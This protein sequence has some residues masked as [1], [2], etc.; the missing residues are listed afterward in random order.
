MKITAIRKS[1][2]EPLRNLYFKVRRGT[3][4]WLD[5]SEF[6]LKDFDR[7]TKGELI[8]VAHLNDIPV[9]FISIWMRDHFIHHLY[10]DQQ[11]QGKN[12]GTQLLKAAIAKTQLPI[13]LKC[14]ENNLKAVDFYLKK[15]FIAIERGQS[16]HGG[17][18][19]FELS[20]NIN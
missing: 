19:L 16:D 9:G 20:E 11:H 18:I 13:T 12:I 3:F 2:F 1:D 8:L 10:I 17:Y 4:L 14:L 7:D 6:Q 15:G 5:P